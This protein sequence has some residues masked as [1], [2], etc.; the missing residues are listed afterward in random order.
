VP[1]SAGT[2]DVLGEPLERLRRD[3]LGFARTVQ[4]VYQDPYES[5]DPRW[6]I[7][8]VLEEPA[9]IHR[10]A[11]SAPE[12]ARLCAEALDRAG[13]TPA[14]DYLDRLPQELSGGQRQRVAIAVSLMLR[15]RLLLADEPVAMLDVSVRAAILDLLDGLRREDDMGLLMVTHDLSTAVQYADRVLVMHR[16]EIVEERPAARFVA[17]ASHPY[18]QALIG[19]IPRLPRVESTDGLA[20]ASS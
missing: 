18:S 19:A 16:G 13:L 5:L 3:R 4:I 12:R 7:R 6:T 10:L 8:E 15:P 1:L 2:C 14:G 17:D 11:D 9:R 20:S